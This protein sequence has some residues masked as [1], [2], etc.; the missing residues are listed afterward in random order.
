M[1]DVLNIGI[2]EDCAEINFGSVSKVISLKDL[3]SCFDKSLD[4]E[5]NSTL[6]PIVLPRNTLMF[7]KNINSMELNTYWP[8]MVSEITFK[9]M[10]GK[11]SIPI[12]NVVIH[13][14]LELNSNDTYSVHARYFCTQKKPGE[15][16]TT[17][18]FI[19][20]ADS[21][22][23]IYLLPLPNIF[24]DGRAC[25]G[26]NTMPN[27]FKTDLR[28]LDWYYLFLINS[29]FNS[30]L[31]VPGSTI[32]SPADYIKFLKGKTEFPYSE[33]LRVR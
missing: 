22:K 1:R 8:E 16:D 32:S 24:G 27:G 31:S 14:K 9:G 30:D 13:M 6:T 21:S 25:Y 26:G 7:A 33:V 23:G 4:S 18:G 29:Q 15:L 10:T 3:K 2:K 17:G 12:P 20:K 19:S 5:D 11:I 28:G